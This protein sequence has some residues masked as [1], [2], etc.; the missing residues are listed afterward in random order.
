M[1]CHESFNGFPREMIDFLWEL[2]FNNNKE[3]FDNNRDRYKTLIKEPMDSFALQLCDEI[4]A[5]TKNSLIPSVSRINRDVRFSKNKEPYR[6]NKWIVFKREEG[7]WKTKAVLFFE[8]GPDYYITGMGVYE[9]S[10]AYMKAFRD[11]ID[12]NEAAFERLIKKYD[13][14]KNYVLTGDLYKKKLGDKSEYVMNWY[15]RKNIAL[16][17]KHEI[18]DIFFEREFLNYCANEFKFLSPLVDFMQD[19]VAG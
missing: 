11:K 8:V 4:T 6:D 15:Q 3:W 5:K 17:Y 12:A 13:K 2:R 1:K 18:D 7:D 9:S 16:I 10:P 19:I 14:N